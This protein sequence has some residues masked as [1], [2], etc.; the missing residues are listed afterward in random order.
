M[1]Q[2]H[3]NTDTFNCQVSKL[4][5]KTQIK[6]ECNKRIENW[7]VTQGQE[8]KAQKIRECAT[9]LGFS[10]INGIAH[11]VKANFCRERVCCVC[12]WRRQSK[13]VAQM[14]PV[15]EYITDKGYKYLFVTLTVQNVRY[16]ELEDCLDNML[17][18]YDKLLHHKKIK[19]AWCGKIRS[20]ELT[21]NSSSFTFHP[22]I[23]I[24][25]AVK[26]DYFSNSELYISQ[27]ELICHWKKALDIE[28]IPVCDIRAVSSSEKGMVETLKYAL[29][30]TPHE[31][32]LKGFFYILK[33]RRLVSFSGVFAEVRKLFKFSSFEE[34][35]TDDL[36]QS[37]KKRFECLLF[38]FD[39]TGGV[40][41]YYEKLYY[42]RE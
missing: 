32:A 38:K 10:N 24:L 23:H 15:L 19:R 28:Y 34:N 17:K 26:E 29:K 16:D 14:L 35:L 37:N 9:M 25:V 8:E 33:G 42:E 30:P 12:A 41:R 31:E 6:K 22:H 40:Y 11:V 1:V 18:A 4:I 2:E 7:L 36:P 13:F 5:Q 20:L 3:N 21:Y 27:N 39:T